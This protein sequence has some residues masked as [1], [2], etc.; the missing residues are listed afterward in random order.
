MSACSG[1]PPPFAWPLGLERALTAATIGTRLGLVVAAVLGVRRHDAV[2]APR[3]GARS[4][5]AARA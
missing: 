3:A 1:T 5:V 2:T 4:P